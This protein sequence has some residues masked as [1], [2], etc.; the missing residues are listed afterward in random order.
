MLPAR[1]S[2]TLGRQGRLRCRLDAV[3]RADRSVAA[4]CADVFE[5]DFDGTRG[6]VLPRDLANRR[7]LSIDSRIDITLEARLGT[8]RWA[9]WRRAQAEPIHPNDDVTIDMS[10]DTTG[11]AGA[12]DDAH[13][14][15]A[16]DQAHVNAL[17]RRAAAEMAVIQAAIDG[18]DRDQELRRMR[19]ALARADRDTAPAGNVTPEE[20]SAERRRQHEIQALYRTVRDSRLAAGGATLSHEAGAGA[21]GQGSR[22]MRPGRG[23]TG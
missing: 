11:T 8:R 14:G 22:A 13:D 9:F 1:L 15:M 4:S 23:I 16:S 19:M 21:V 2:P 12:R 3:R 5:S 10:D 6:L 20:A 7:G 17:R 18:P